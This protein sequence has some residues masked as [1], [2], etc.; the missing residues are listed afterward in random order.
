MN[1]IVDIGNTL[2][3]VAQFELGNC[4]NIERFKDPSLFLKY[5]SSMSA[6]N[7]IL[8]SVREV[9]FTNDVL[10]LFSDSL[11]LTTKTHLP[12][13][14]TYKTPETLGNDRIANAV[15]AFTAF[16]NQNT[17]TIDLGTC[18]KFD[19]INANNEYLGGSISPGLKMR[20][21]A[22]HTLTD[23][24][25]LIDDVEINQLI[26]TDTTSSIQVGVCQGMI[27][28][29]T[30]MI[31]QYEKKYDKLN[32][33]LTGGDLRWFLD[34]EMSQKNSIFADE[35]HTLKGLNTILDYN[36]QK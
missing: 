5:V 36:V 24:L 8:S 22:L 16:P 29:I 25:P 14:N 17:L 10:N 4:R 33:I 34:I 20:F 6:N 31:R 13:T 27:G 18:I 23:N 26:G 11:L 1:L 35:F 28:E 15:G 3:K 32:I 9:S 30:N 2:I 21:N 19:F 12:I 7:V